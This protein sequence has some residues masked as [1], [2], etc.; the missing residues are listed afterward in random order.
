MKADAATVDAPAAAGQAGDSRR[1][2]VSF[3]AR[4]LRSAVA[5]AALV[6]LVYCVWLVIAFAAG[7]TVWNFILIG[8]K[9]APHMAHAVSG[10]GYDGQFSY[11]LATDPLHA[12]V[13]MD[14]PAYRYT[15]ILY[16]LVA[17]LFALGQVRLVPYSLILVNV[18]AVAGGTWAVAAWSVRRGLNPWLALIYGLF[19]GLFTAFLR[20]LTEPLAY[21][22]VALAVYLYE[23]GGRRRLLLAGCALGLACLARETA[24]IF[25]FVYVLGPLF[26][27]DS[28]SRRIKVAI[29]I[30]LPALAPFAVY[31]LFLA[32]WLHASGL[33]SSG[34]G[35]AFGLVPFAGALG[36]LSAL[37]R[38]IAVLT[39]IM[40]A[41]VCACVAIRAW[42]SGRFLPQ[43]WALL[44][45]IQV[46]VVMLD[47]ASYVD[48]FGSERVSTGVLLAALY[49]VPL[50]GSV[51]VV[52]RWFAI[53]ATG[54]LLMA[55]FYLV[56]TP[57]WL[58]AR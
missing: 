15:R 6:L 25:A 56:I 41:L 8:V 31:K 30:G 7:D 32:L 55:P 45:N 42:R 13:H 24:G 17:R 27:T 48:S 34:H 12:R 3:R 29:S 11:Y 26:T 47:A 19:P 38:S 21:A 40:P 43:W 9:F 10:T 23:F 5:P 53:A 33:P 44:G 37:N 14:N 2:I 49:C 35:Q 51:V 52:R 46:C 18:L 28:L 22:L 58:A 16:P 20:D 57:L 39:V 4:I 50:F 1:G 54:W 36:P